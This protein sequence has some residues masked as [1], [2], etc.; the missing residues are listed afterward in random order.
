MTAIAREEALAE[1]RAEQAALRQKARRAE[2]VQAASKRC[3]RTFKVAS[4]VADEGAAL[5]DRKKVVSSIFRNDTA[6]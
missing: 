2:Q 3:R 6:T 1:R 5:A 4:P